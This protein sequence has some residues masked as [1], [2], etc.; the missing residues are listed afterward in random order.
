M[1]VPNNKLYQN[2]R[3][4]NIVLKYLFKSYL[5][6]IKFFSLNDKNDFE[7][8]ESSLLRVL[9]TEGYTVMS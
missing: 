3:I 8:F 4:L 6:I 2:I 9:D 7:D 1:N 5:Y